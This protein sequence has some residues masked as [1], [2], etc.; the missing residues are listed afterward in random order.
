MILVLKSVDNKSE[1]KGKYTNVM[2]V[3][4][5]ITTVSSSIFLFSLCNQLRRIILTVLVNLGSWLFTEFHKY[6]FFVSGHSQEGQPRPSR[7][8]VPLRP[9]PSI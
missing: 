6:F 5:R 1:V 9:P 2:R 7:R 3:M 4:I 8:L